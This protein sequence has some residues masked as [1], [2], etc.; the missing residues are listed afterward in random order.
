MVKN[1]K[2]P[3]FETAV[4]ELE[5]IVQEMENGQLP[6]DQALASYQ[7]G[8]Q[9]LRQCQDLLSNAEQSI[10]VIEAATPEAPQP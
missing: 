8:T 10:R 4:S 6:L 3:S 9:L 7:R 5:S 2:S 1:S